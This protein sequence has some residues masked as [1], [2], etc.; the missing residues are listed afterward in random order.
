MDEGTLKKEVRKQVETSENIC[1]YVA[2]EGEC[3]NGG[4]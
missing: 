2:G 4:Q 1:G 3:E